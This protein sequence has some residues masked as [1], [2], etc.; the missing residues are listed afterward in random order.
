MSFAMSALQITLE[1][2]VNSSANVCMAS[3]MMVAR[4]SAP[5]R[6]TSGMQGNFVMSNAVE[7]SLYLARCT[8]FVFA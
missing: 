6:A 8:E 2:S 3:V 4:V 5:A 7:A 1:F